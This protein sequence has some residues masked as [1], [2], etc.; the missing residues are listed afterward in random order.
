MPK[1]SPKKVTGGPMPQGTMVQNFRELCFVVLLVTRMVAEEIKILRG[2]PKTFTPKG[3][4][5]ETALHTTGALDSKFLP[6]EHCKKSNYKLSLSLG[7]VD[8]DP[9]GLSM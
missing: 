8:L 4:L 7:P 2:K 3:T 1:T 5:C 6:V 9:C